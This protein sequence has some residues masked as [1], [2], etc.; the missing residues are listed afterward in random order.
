MRQV[1]GRVL[2]SLRAGSALPVASLARDLALPPER[3]ADAVEGLVRD[4]LASR[5]PDGRIRLAD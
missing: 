1:R 4:G 5:T 3:V 2:A